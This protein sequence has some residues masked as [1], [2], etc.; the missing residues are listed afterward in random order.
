MF[1]PWVGS[2]F[3]T[4]GSPLASKRL[5][6]LGE[7][8]HAEEHPVGAVVPSMTRDVFWK[9]RNEPWCRWMRTFDNIAAAVTGVKKSEVGVAGVH[10]FWDQVA[11]YNYVPVVAAGAARQRPM[12]AQFK[13]GDE[14]FRLQLAELQPGA[15]IVCG[16][17]LWARMTAVHAQQYA[18]DPWRPSSAFARLGEARIPA[19]RMVHPST[20]FS[21]RRWTPLIRELLNM[22]RGTEELS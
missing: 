16:Y 15:V 8:H 11:F 12:P 19:L 3:G 18:D 4:A 6:V 20:A 14:P 10:A 7:S 22:R 9:Y 1:T 17:E 13:A 5:L 2:R 21:P